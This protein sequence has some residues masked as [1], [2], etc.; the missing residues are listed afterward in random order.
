MESFTWSTKLADFRQISRSQFKEERMEDQL[1]HLIVT[2]NKDG[3]GFH[4]SF[5]KDYDKSTRLISC[6]H[7]HTK[8]GYFERLQYRSKEVESF[9]SV[10]FEANPR[11]Q[12]K[13]TEETKVKGNGRKKVLILGKTG[14]GKSAL[15]NV[16]AGKLHDANLFPVS[17]D[18]SS[19]TQETKI[20]DVNFNNDVGKPISLI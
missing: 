11:K 16:I 10:Q 18:P 20:A 3:N 5:V 9:F 13:K 19:C 4:T 2:R 1:E 6:D 12:Q 8:Q 14:T 15:C 7:R 17:A